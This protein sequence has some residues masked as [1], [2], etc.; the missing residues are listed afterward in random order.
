MNPR[1]RPPRRHLDTQPEP[2]GL[3]PREVLK[4]VRRF[5]AEGLLGMEVVEVS[6]PY[7]RAV[8]VG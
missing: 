4:L 3:Y 8:A 2:G 7:D 5:A 6:P 1:P